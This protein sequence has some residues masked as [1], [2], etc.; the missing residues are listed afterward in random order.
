MDIILEVLFDVACLAIDTAATSSRSGDND[1]PIFQ[2]NKNYTSQELM[3]GKK[4]NT[5]IY[6]TNF[7]KDVYKELKS[8]Y[9][10]K[11]ISKY[12]Y[13]NLV[14]HQKLMDAFYKQIE[15]LKKIDKMP[16]EKAYRS[17]EEIDDLTKQLYTEGK[18]SK[19]KY[20]QVN[21][22]VVKAQETYR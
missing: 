17:L 1:A 18:I 11:A 19:E 12:E 6:Q 14:K 8:L 4:L 7:D 2:G 5:G 10:R 3:E 22:L 15:V 13:E 21:E 16:K 20:L 9:R